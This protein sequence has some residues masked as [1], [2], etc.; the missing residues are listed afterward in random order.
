[1]TDGKDVGGVTESR[2]ETTGA[3]TSEQIAFLG[4][5]RMGAAMAERLA[6]AHGELV[7]WNRSEAKAREFVEK[8]G[9][10]AR[11]L[12][13]ASPREAV[14]QASVVVTMLA[15]EQAL[16]AVLSGPDGGLAGIRPG[17]LWVDMS[18]VGPEAVAQSAARLAEHGAALVDAP[19]SGSVSFAQSGTLAVM[20]GGA[21]ADV[22]RARRALQTLANKWLPCGPSGAG[23]ALKLGVNLVVHALN[24]AVSEAL[25]A[26]ERAGVSRSTAFELFTNSAVA[27]PFI[28]YKRA[29][30]E[31]PETAP[32]AFALDLVAKDLR[33][34]TAL[35]RQVGAPTQV[36]ETVAAL[37]GAACEHG[38]GDRDMSAL[39]VHLRNGAGK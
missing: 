13:A 31:E 28:G 20:A 37:V 38:F 15:D 3:E 19:V 34:I 16:D 18:T 17:S 21:D 6:L 24:A 33:L 25:V 29:S 1:M 8:V 12:I 9:D 22:E 5:G 23:A 7:V 30:F 4:L 11:V 36:S 27:A 35:E 2:S 32:V 14:S 10:R 39:A 26:V